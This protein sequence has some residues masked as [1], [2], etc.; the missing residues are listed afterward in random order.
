VLGDLME[1]IGIA[2]DVPG[3]RMFVTEHG[4][5]DLFG[6]TR[7][8]RQT[9]SGHRAGKPCRNRVRGYIFLRSGLTRR[10]IRTIPVYMLL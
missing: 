4:G 9:S 5:G 8:V 2:L 10:F 7:R 3:G 6:E 1:G